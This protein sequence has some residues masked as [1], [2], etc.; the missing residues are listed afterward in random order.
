MA[1]HHIGG[2]FIF[3]LREKSTQLL[4]FCSIEPVIRVEPEDPFAR[5]VAERQLGIIKKLV[6]L[7]PGYTS[8]P[9][10]KDLPKIFLTFYQINQD[11]NKVNEID[12]LL[13]AR[14]AGD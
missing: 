8:R 2:V 1:L 3:E 10:L 13:K 14:G 6:D 12:A 5:R 9:D 4:P 7:S 11:V